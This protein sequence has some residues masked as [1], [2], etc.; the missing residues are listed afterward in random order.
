MRDLKTCLFFSM[1]Q[2]SSG[3][4]YDNSTSTSSVTYLGYLTEGFCFKF[5]EEKTNAEF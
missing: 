5:V 4:C 3:H 1:K 2:S